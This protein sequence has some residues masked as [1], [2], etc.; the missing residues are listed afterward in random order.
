[1][2]SEN[3]S[4]ARRHYKVFMNGGDTLTK[5]AV[6]AIIDQWI[7]GDEEFIDRVIEKYEC[8]IKREPKKRAYPLYGDLPSGR[9]P[10]CRPP[11]TNSGHQAK[12]ERSC[13]HGGS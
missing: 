2:V 4:R 12:S 10:L 9:D 11:S 8:D 7:Q 13:G 6:S 5:E 3:K 1:M